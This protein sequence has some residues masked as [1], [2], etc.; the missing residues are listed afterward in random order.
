MEDAKRFAVFVKEAEQVVRRPYDLI[1][2]PTGTY[3]L[4]HHG[5]RPRIPE[6]Y[7][8]IRIYDER[9]PFDLER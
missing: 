6:T 2:A 9:P 5:A 1:V 4:P 8:G 3:L 7:D